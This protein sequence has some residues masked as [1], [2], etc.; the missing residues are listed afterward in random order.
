MD[1]KE[2]LDKKVSFQTTARTRL[3]KEMTIQ[4]VLN[5]IKS[6][7]YFPEIERLRTFIK[8]GQLKEYDLNKKILPAVTFCGTFD[9]KRRREL[10]K[11]YNRIIV[12]DIDKL[13]ALEFKRVKNILQENEFVFTSWESPSQKGL[14]GLVYLSYQYEVENS[15]IDTCHKSAFKQ[16]EKYFSETYN[17]TLDDSGSDTTR[18]CF[19]SYDLNL[20]LKN[21]FSPFLI[22]EL[23]IPQDEISDKKENTTIKAASKLDALYNPANK[24]NPYNRKTIQSIIKFLTKHNLSI[25]YDYDDWYQV[26]LSIAATFTYEIGEKYYLRLCRI[27]KN[28][29]NE[30]ACKNQLIYSYENRKNIITFDK[31]K[32]LAIKKGYKIKN[33]RGAVAKVANESMSHVS[34][35]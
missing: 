26:S 14:K 12:L 23:E 22:T 6:N 8:N 21:N 15:N 34:A 16:L 1:I 10:L 17:I 20:T 33:R 35:L 9:K 27:D 30:V 19:V 31:I 4:E 11:T 29:F 32:S 13:D 5:E 7:K 25:T 28:K 24:N 2:L 3:S 18:L